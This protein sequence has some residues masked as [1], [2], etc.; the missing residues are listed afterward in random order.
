[1]NDSVSDDVR[2]CSAELVGMAQ[3]HGGGEIGAATL[4]NGSIDPLAGPRR[5]HAPGDG[6]A[7]QVIAAT[8]GHVRVHI[9]AELIKRGARSVVAVPG[10]NAVGGRDLPAV[11]IEAAAPE[12]PH[13]N[14]ANIIRTS[15]L[16]K[17]SGREISQRE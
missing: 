5:R 6:A 13:P 11:E 2:D 15:I 4:I 16:G 9:S 17:Y 7:I 10:Q 12:A 1:M 8:D 3:V 14:T